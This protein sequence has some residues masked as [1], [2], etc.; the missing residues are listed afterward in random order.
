[1]AIACSCDLGGGNLGRPNCFPIF[2]VTK[3]AILTEYFKSDGTINGILL[4]SLS[5]VVDQ[6]FLDG[7]FKAND[8]MDRWFITPELKNIVDVR[9]DD[10]T[11]TFEDTSSVFIQDGARNFEGMIIKGDPVL[12]GNLQSWK[13]QTAGVYFV[14][15][16]GNLIGALSA[17]GLSLNPIRIQDESF[18]SSLVKTTDTTIQKASMRFTVS[19]LED[20]ANLHM[21]ESSN[22]TGILLGARGLVD[23]VAKAATAITATSFTVQINTKFG[24]V[25]NP[26]PATGL[27]TADFSGLELSP[28]PGAAVITSVTESVV[29][30]GLYDWVIV[31]VSGDEL[32]YGN[33][34][35]S[36][37]GNI[38]DI[39]DFDVT[40]P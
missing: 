34:L 38:F 4:S 39:A 1:M 30:A 28:T 18:S 14:D 5:G 16:N 19:Q 26:I 24:G 33:T 6:T 27:V 15:I 22:I 12:T 23:A 37:L 35:A 10:I 21:I 40:I 29:T 20:D 2:G 32:R 7:K 8:P 31:A 25:L 36:T 11:E 9:E 3:Q 13:C 17:D